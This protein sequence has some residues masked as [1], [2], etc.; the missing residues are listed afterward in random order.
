MIATLSLAVFQA[1]AADPPPTELAGRSVAMNLVKAAGL[2]PVPWPQGTFTLKTI[3]TKLPANP[4]LYHVLLDN[5]IAPDTEAFTLVYD[6]NPRFRDLKSVSAGGILEL[7]LVGGPTELAQLKRSGYLVQLTIDQELRAELKASTDR[8]HAVTQ[9][10]MQHSPKPFASATEPTPNKRADTQEQ[11]A[12]LSKWFDQINT[13]YL[14]H[15][16]PPL[17]RRTLVQLRDE[18]GVLVSL[19]TKPTNSDQKLSQEDQEQIAAIY[20]DV[21]LDIQK[22]GQ[23][24]G[25]TGPKADALYSVIVNV[26]G[27]DVQLIQGLRVYWAINGIFRDPPINPPVISYGFK[28]LGSGKSEML[29]I[30]NYRIW[31]ARDGDPGHPVTPPLLVSVLGTEDPVH[32]DLSLVPRIP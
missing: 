13:S 4:N 15:T 24:L 11:I 22:Y 25:P 8:L 6:L 12:T 7:P 28:E 19:L 9:D 14:R 30:K 29:P 3:E 21:A 2:A 1:A 23:V 26:V 10:F 27:Q 31:A 32:V 17:R 20:S 18:A 5:G 16:G